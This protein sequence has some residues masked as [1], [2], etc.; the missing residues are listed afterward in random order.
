MNLQSAVTTCQFS[1]QDTPHHN[2]THLSCELI[3]I[4]KGSAR[5][6]IQN[7]LYT[8]GPNSLVFI[9]TMEEHSVQILERPYERYFFSISSA[10]LEKQIRNP[11]LTSIFKNRP[12]GFNHVYPVKEEADHIE[13]LLQQITAEYGN[14][15]TFSGEMIGTFL[16]QILILLYRR[17]P[18]SF[19]LPDRLVNNE[20]LSIQRHI[21]HHFTENISI[22][23]LAEDHFISSDYLSHVFKQLTGYSPKQY[24]LLNRLVYAREL[25]LRNE[26]PINVVA[27]KSGFNDVNNF[28]RAYKKQFGTTPKQNR[29]E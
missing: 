27:F 12:E 8:V 16:E 20:I 9:N 28:I 22:T 6:E 3:Y 15:K 7:K 29:K 21:E 11:K 23:Q 2:H 26:F 10:I 19:P 14:P 4:R 13:A 18:D 1:D 24:I 25:V 17:Y 5:F